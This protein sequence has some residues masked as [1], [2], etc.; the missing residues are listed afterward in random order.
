MRTSPLTHLRSCSAL[1]AASFALASLS[2]QQALADDAALQ[3]Q[4]EALQRQVASLQAQM[5]QL[6]APANASGARP[7]V[8]SSPTLAPAAAPAAT[9]A[10]T[11]AAAPAASSEFGNAAD[12]VA[13]TVIG[14]YGEFI[15]NRFRKDRSRDQAD[16]RRFVLFVSHR[17][18][19][20][21]AFN[22]EVEVEHAVSSAEDVGEVAMEQAYLSYDLQPGL[23]LK[24]GLFHMPFGFLNQA[25][26]PPVFFGVERNEVE[27][28]I[29]PTTWR[30]AGFALTGRMEGGFSWEAGITT[31]LNLGNIEGT[32]RPVRNARQEAAEA[33]ARD[34][35]GYA[36]LNYRGLP[37]LTV[38]GALFRGNTN[39]GNAAFQADNARPNFAGIDAPVTLWDVHARWQPGAFDLQAL[40]AQGTFGDAGRIDR[41]V[42]DFNLAN[43][44]SHP[45]VPDRFYGWL[46]QAAYTA[47]QR[48]GF[49][50]TPFVRHE[51]FNSQAAMPAGFAANPANED[52]VTTVG[53]SLKPHPQVVFKADYQ[54]FHDDPRGDRFN[55]G[56]GYMF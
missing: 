12:R 37:G 38:G 55:L 4:V 1:L 41:I 19:D 8:P 54:W 21:L 2:P 35:A 18:D 43:G 39:Q 45:L 27:T 5:T 6:L 24:G 48:G 44:A 31:S 42:Q 33:R 52:H 9:S 15:Y 51:R 10:A 28:R 16:L 17:F 34:L 26:E 56:L 40:Y 53:F 13:D 22:S 29:I 46:T 3:A 25:H 36:A 14:G 23:T 20:R 30:E 47:W 11:S 50:F 49:S 7:S 32:S